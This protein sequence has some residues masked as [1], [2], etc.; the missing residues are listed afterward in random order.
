MGKNDFV[1]VAKDFAFSE[2]ERTSMPLAQHIELSTE[3]GMKIA[4]RLKADS[5]IVEAG[6]YL[7]D[8]MIGQALKENRLQDHIKMS[9]DKTEE[10]L[11]DFGLSSQDKENII[12]CVLEHH[13]AKKFYS[14]E[15]EI[16][17]NADCYR[18][19]SIIGFS[20]AMRF[21]RDMPF[22]DLVVLLENKVKE[23][24]NALS[25]EICKKEIEPQYA[26][27]KKFVEE[28]KK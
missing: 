14:L 5:Q 24:W 13:G 27:I 19:I 10:L 7:M 18:F 22:S 6:T 23:K 21:L 9:A 28:L 4:K 17:C 16:C 2:Q 20:Y 1:K 25:L 12:H 15:S 8:C 26:L 11:Q 3:V